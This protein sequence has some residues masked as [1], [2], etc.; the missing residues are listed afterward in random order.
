MKNCNLSKIKNNFKKI[1]D[2]LGLDLN[3]ENYIDTPERLA[4]FFYEFTE[5]TR[6]GEDSLKEY[7]KINFPSHK[8]QEKSYKGIL[9]QSPIL[10]YSVCSHHFI[11]IIYTISFAYVPN[12]DCQIGFSKI[13]RIL[14]CIA[15]NPSNQED[16]TQNV[17][18]IFSKNLN[19][20]GVAVLI[21]GIHFCMKIRGVN[22]D[23]NNT[24]FAMSGI[25]QEDKEFRD[26][27]FELIN[28]N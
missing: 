5:F 2:L 11:P 9:F 21:S 19:C 1:L 12:K 23:A 16:F 10:V 15:K 4:K 20:S 6:A 8:N 17:V 27:F 14:K 13:I 3:D 26:R 7:F 22:S 28:I 18:D 24:T 25:F